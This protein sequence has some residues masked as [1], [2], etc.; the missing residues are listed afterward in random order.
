MRALVPE[1]GGVIDL[2][3]D[4]RDLANLVAEQESRPDRKPWAPVT[5]AGGTELEEA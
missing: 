1:L 3:P 5:D 2:D 4:N